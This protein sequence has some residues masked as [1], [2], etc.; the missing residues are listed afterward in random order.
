ADAVV[1]AVPME[2]VIFSGECAL[3]VFMARNLELI[4]CQLFFPLGVWLANFFH[5]GHSYALPCRIKFHDSNFLWRLPRRRFS[6]AGKEAVHAKAAQRHHKK[7]SAMIAPVL[8]LRPPGT[9]IELQNF[10]CYLPL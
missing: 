10:H 3:G 2:V 9:C 8:D 7:R 6:V 1:N 5:F 4:G